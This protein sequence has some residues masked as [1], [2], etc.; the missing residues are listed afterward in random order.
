[1]RAK[2]LSND[3]KSLRGYRHLKHRASTLVAAGVVRTFLRKKNSTQKPKVF[4][5][6]VVNNND[7]SLFCKQRKASRKR[8]HFWPEPS[9]PHRSFFKH[10]SSYIDTLKKASMLVQQRT[11]HLYFLLQSGQ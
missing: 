9:R 8:R 4:L 5:I 10:K 7:T 11:C 1:M 3:K 6:R 2:Q